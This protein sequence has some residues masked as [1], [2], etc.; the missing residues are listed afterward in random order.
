MSI[1]VRAAIRLHPAAWRERYEDEV[2]GTLQD[3]AD[4]RHG[5]RI[6]LSE[7]VP[8]GF[9]GLWLRARVSVTFWAGLVVIMLLVANAV[10]ADVGY[11]GGSL[12]D[13]LLRLNTG[14]GYA[15]PVL[16]VAGGWAGARGRLARIVGARRRLRRLW[17]DTWPLLT[18][19]AVGYAIAVVVIAVR[20]GLS[21]APG[22][23]LFIIFAQWAMVLIAVAI[24]ELLGAVFPRVLVIFAAPAVTMF[25]AV[26]LITSQTSWNVAPQG[27][28]SGIAYVFEVE[29]YTRVILIAGVVVA[30]S[31]VV[32]AVRP[33]WL[34][35]L[36]VAALVAIGAVVGA[37]PSP[38]LDEAA[39]VERSHSEL[40][41][42]T[43]EPVVCLWPEQE[44]AFGTSLRARMVEAYGTASALGMPVESA[45]PR[46]VARYAMTGIPHPD[47]AWNSASLMGLGT[48]GF[49]PDDLLPWYAY[50]MTSCC[51]EE[52]TSGDGEYSAVA[53]ASSILLGVPPEQALPAVVDPYTGQQNIDPSDVPDEKTARTLVDEWLSDGVNGVRSPE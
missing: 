48:A 52:P 31:V 49:S 46:S 6:P 1:A 36:P 47:Y 41:C 33:V 34:R 19:T 17:G 44:A 3:V 2:L 8:L 12:I 13:V 28:Y 14:V 38:Q 45:G 9:R 43:A 15:L 40:I 23:S 53:Y 35:L 37:Q 11:L 20:S 16:A 18:F 30:A 22:V 10:T 7:S 39:A 4:E 24:G 42:S 5:G 25:A 27:L 51:F 26:L 29:P 32:T 21:W 50:A